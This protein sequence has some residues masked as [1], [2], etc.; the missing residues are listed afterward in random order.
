MSVLNHECSLNTRTVL[1]IQWTY[2]L[3]QWYPAKQLGNKQNKNVG[4]NRQKLCDA[5]YR[6]GQNEKGQNNNMTRICDV[7]NNRSICQ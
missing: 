3:F 5:D 2:Q 7:N 6:K 1:S 4:K